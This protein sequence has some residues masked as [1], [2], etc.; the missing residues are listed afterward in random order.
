MYPDFIGIGAQKSGTTWLYRNLRNHPGIWIP[1]KEVHYFDHKI[2]EAP[3]FSLRSKVFGKD[4]ADKRW[5]NQVKYWTG[6]HLRNRSL[7]GLLWVYRF[8]MR[9]PGDEWYASIFEPRKGRI[10]GEITPNYSVLDRDMIGHVHDLMP[11]AKIILMTRN[12]IERAWSQAVM[13]FDK[14]EKQPVETVSVKQFRKFRKNQS[15]LLTDYLRTLENWGAYYPPEQIF[16][17]FLEDIHFY[18]NR[19]L[20]RLYGF[21]GASSSPENYKVIRRKVHSRDVET[22]PTAVASRLAQTYLEDAR[23]LEERFGGYAS[24]WRH[25]AERLAGEP[26]GGEHIAYPLYNSALWEEWVAQRGG[27]PEPGSREAEPHSGRL[28][29]IQARPESG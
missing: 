20:R 21:L 13:Y 18:P 25:S 2:K 8:Y 15:S 10:A 17:G 23:R 16:V 22:M 29:S 5:R 28:S 11:E 1:R 26:P 24:F 19:L 12:P 14:V 7:T 3:S 6:V 4:E 9:A 27:G